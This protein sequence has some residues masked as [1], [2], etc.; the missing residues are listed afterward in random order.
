MCSKVRAR[1]NSHCKLTLNEIVMESQ[2]YKA[3]ET[4]LHAQHLEH[5][6]MYV[7]IKKHP[8]SWAQLCKAC[9]CPDPEHHR[10]VMN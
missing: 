7:C 5:K 10:S 9:S 3:W 2:I 1:A 6:Q 4:S 8:Y